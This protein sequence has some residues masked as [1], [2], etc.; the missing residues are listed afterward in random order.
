MLD[1]PPPKKKKKYM[2]KRTRTKLKKTS[3]KRLE[4]S[5]SGAVIFVE[6]VDSPQWF[7]LDII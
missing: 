6:I 1:D 5:E 7:K 2:E 3:W 4:V